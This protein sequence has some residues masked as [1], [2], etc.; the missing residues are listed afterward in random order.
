MQINA[1]G[2]FYEQNS[3][4]AVL[5]PENIKKMEE[6]ANREITRQCSASI[7]RAQFL[8]SD[9]FGWGR[10]VESASPETW[11]R[12]T[13]QWNEVFSEVEADVQVK[14]SIRRTYLTDSSFVFR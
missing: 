13:S 1:E 6:L 12:V 8:G 14:F 9:I 4:G 2:N 10:Q 7:A 3:T 5:T 11:K